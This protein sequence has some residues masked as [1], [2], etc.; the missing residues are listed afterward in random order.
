VTS[1]DCPEK[2][3]TVVMP[4]ASPL[5]AVGY[6]QWVLSFEGR[7][8]VR[9]GYDQA[10]LARVAEA[11]AR[12]LMHDMRWEVKARHGLGSVQPLHAGVF[13]AVQRFRS[14]LGLYVHL[15][16]L[17]TDGAFEQ[18]GEGLRFLSAR[19]PT[20]QR[21]TA[22]LAQVHKAVAAATDA[23]DDDDALDLDPALAACVQLALAGPHALP[24]QEP[25]ARPSLTLSAFG[26]HLH[27]ATTV[28]GRDR[29]QLERMC[30][31]MLRPPFAHDAVKALPDGRVRVLFKAP[32]RSGVAHA[33][34]APDKFLARLCALVPPPGFHML[35]YFG[36]F[37][38]H[39]HLRARVI[40]P[41]AA[42]PE[43]QLALDLTAAANDTS[44]SPTDASPRPRRLGW[45]KLLA[46]VF[47]VDVTVCR[48]CGGRMR[49]LEVV[50][51]PDDIARV[52]HGARAPPPPPRSRR[53]GNGKGPPHATRGARGQ[54]AN[55]R[56]IA[57]L[58][59]SAPRRR[60]VLAAASR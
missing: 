31:Y 1:W 24:P 46:R 34:M 23:E 57:R 54:P 43:L 8:A 17:V 47:A 9:L 2:V 33:D 51:D 55:N 35:R 13:T 10:L 58:G 38:S 16:C 32:W 40:P 6:R 22:A 52:L 44:S 11:F 59:C 36:V 5:P 26:M 37:A 25:A 27:A 28:D 56:A 7:M 4:P 14:D 18:A 60:S 41:A 45:A 29:K 53:P 39:H 15:H 21:M 30:R 20:P 12:A 42:M 48:K 19:T 50:S 49:V 3:D